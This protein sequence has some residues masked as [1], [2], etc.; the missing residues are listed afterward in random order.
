M[1]ALITL[2]LIVALY[3]LNDGLRFELIRSL[4]HRPLHTAQL[5]LLRLL[6]VL[7]MGWLW[8]WLITLWSQTGTLGLLMAVFT[9]AMA[10]T[11]LWMMGWIRTYIAEPS[12]PPRPAG[13][14]EVSLSSLL[15]FNLWL[16]TLTLPA[17]LVAFLDTP[18]LLILLLASTLFALGDALLIVL[19]GHGQWGD[20]WIRSEKSQR[21]FSRMGG[22]VL[23]VIAVV[24]VMF[25][26]S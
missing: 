17:L 18:S 23:M 19:A 13:I 9:G 21:I 20:Q 22:S 5:A 12:Y 15:S 11:W 10:A 25:S 6:A 8:A 2:L 26:L 24:A 16:A 7:S 3:S 4:Q 14:A 1:T